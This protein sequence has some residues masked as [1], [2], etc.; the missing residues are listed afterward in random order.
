MGNKVEEIRTFLYFLSCTYLL[1]L[2]HSKSTSL[3]DFYQSCMHDCKK[4][5]CRGAD[6]CIVFDRWWHR[7][8]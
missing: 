4:D 3:I 2:Y 7:E 5:I 8:G 6:F 1:P